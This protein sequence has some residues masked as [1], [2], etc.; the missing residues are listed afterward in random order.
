MR[1]VTGVTKEVRMSAEE[2]EFAIVRGNRAI[3][4]RFDL[5]HP[6]AM[7]EVESDGS[8]NGPNPLLPG[9]HIEM[10]LQS[11]DLGPERT[12]DVGDAPYAEL[13]A[14]MVQHA[15]LQLLEQHLC[16]AFDGLLPLDLREGSVGRIEVILGEPRGQ[17]VAEKFRELF[18]ERFRD[19]ISTRHAPFT[20]G[21]TRQLYNEAIAT[22]GHHGP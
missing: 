8:V 4:Y 20:T 18:V 6:V 12:V 14:S 3:V 16:A 21:K 7:I 9:M 22:Y 15:T 2:E 13:T 17:A 11:G 10:W 5:S 19:C 1:L